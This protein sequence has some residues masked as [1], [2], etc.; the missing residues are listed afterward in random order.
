MKTSK[1]LCANHAMLNANN[2]NTPQIFVFHVQDLSYFS[3]ILVSP[4]AP[5]AIS[6]MAQ[7]VLLA[8]ILANNV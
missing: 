2:A 5:P 6:V 7:N 4:R 1:L 3:T 8:L